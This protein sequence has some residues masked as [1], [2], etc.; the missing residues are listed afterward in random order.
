MSFIAGCFILSLSS[1]ISRCAIQERWSLLC[2][3]LRLPQYKGTLAS[4]LIYNLIPVLLLLWKHLPKVLI[5]FFCFTNESLSCWPSWRFYN[6]QK[7]LSRFIKQSFLIYL[8]LG[9]LSHKMLCP[10][11]SFSTLERPLSHCLLT[12]YVLLARAARSKAAPHSACHPI[13]AFVL[14]EARLSC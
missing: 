8:L 5:F 13:D 3:S 11:R 9:I 7:L 4:E 6:A 1:R 12:F 14:T 2:C 10:C